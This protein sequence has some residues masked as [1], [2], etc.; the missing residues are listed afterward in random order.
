MHLLAESLKQPLYSA[1]GIME[2]LWHF[3][4][5]NA[6]RGDIGSVP[7][8]QIAAAVAWDGKTDKLIDGLVSSV[9]LDRHEE[10]RLVVHDWPE[11]CEQSVRKWLLRNKKGFLPVYG[12]Y[13]PGVQPASGQED[14]VLSVGVLPSR[15]AKALASGSECVSPEEGLG[16]TTEPSR[17]V[18][19][20]AYRDFIDLWQMPCVCCG[21]QFSM[22]D[23]IL[24]GRVWFS[25][26]EQGKITT[27]NLA[28]ITAGLERY[29][30]ST[31][32]HKD[33]GKYVPSVASWLGWSKNG[34]PA[35]PR[36]RD[37]PT[38]HLKRATGEGY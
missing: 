5:Q 23:E 35:D 24:G 17:R 6:P 30:A 4:G 19:G 15:E 18:A 2:M 14:I 16:E 1:V 33:G 20:A 21:M 34:L 32:W 28:E 7:D 31:D 27:A 29:R 3:V 26:V 13:S 12:N 8:R 10:Y 36:W 22:R 25:L 38:P 37:R 11:H 9:W